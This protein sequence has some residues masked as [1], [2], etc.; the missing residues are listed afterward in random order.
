MIYLIDTCECNC[1]SNY[2]QN[3]VFVMEVGVEKVART[4]KTLNFTS[5]G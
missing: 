3:N 1:Q 5:Q 2:M 4:W